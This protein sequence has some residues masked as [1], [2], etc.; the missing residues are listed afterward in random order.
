VANI[1]IIFV[2]RKVLTLKQ[3]KAPP[4]IGEALMVFVVNLFYIIDL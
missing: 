3:K 4:I 2:K 1:R